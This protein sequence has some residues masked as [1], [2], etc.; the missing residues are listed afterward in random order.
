MPSRARMRGPRV[1][2][3]DEND[4]MLANTSLLG[5]IQ[6]RYDVYD[7]LG[8]WLG[9]MVRDMDSVGHTPWLTATRPFGRAALISSS[10]FRS[11]L[12]VPVMTPP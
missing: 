1:C 7:A 5:T 4:K 8:T 10:E 11:P 3:A 12:I 2:R 6:R 9:C